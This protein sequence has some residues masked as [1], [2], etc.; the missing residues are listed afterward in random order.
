MKSWADLKFW[1]SD[2]YRN[3]LID[4]TDK[5]YYPDR[6]DWFNA[7]KQTPLKTVRA[8]ILGQDPY[9]DGSATGL[10]FSSHKKTS[11]CPPT[12]RNILY[13]YHSDL[14]KAM[15]VSGNL[16]AW[17][18]RGVL[19]INTHWTVAP[20]KAGSH[21]YLG[22]NELTQEIL[23]AVISVNPDTILILWGNEAIETASFLRGAHRVTSSHPSPLSVFKGKTPFKGSRPF[24]KCNAILQN[25]RQ[26]PI[27]WTLPDGSH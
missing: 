27:D 10:A 17:S 26:Q 1:S 4:L 19:M 15:P 16:T 8:V 3:I 13:E 18:R 22:W 9:H 2:T 14:G 23:E 21:V 25:L 11:E 6:E 20:G 7:L 12:L 24:T 5:A